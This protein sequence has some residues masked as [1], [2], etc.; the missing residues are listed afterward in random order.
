MLS[1]IFE[2]NWIKINDISDFNGDAYVALLE[3]WWLSWNDISIN[4]QSIVDSHNVID[5]P[6]FMQWRLITLWWWIIW[7]TE[8]NLISKINDINKSFSV[9]SYYK[10]RKDWYRDLVFYKNWATDNEKYFV[11]A[12]IKKLPRIDK[13]LHIHRKR[14][15][16]LELFCEESFIYSYL[17]KKQ[18]LDWSLNFSLPASL[19]WSLV[20]NRTDIVTNNWNCW[21][22][23]F[24]KITWAFRSIEIENI[25]NWQK[26]VMTWL[27]IVDWEYI[28]IDWKNWI[29]YKNWDK[30]IDLSEYMSLTSDWI[31]LDAWD[32][33][34]VFRWSEYVWNDNMPT[35]EITYRDTFNNIE[36]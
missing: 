4:T 22:T 31:F 17:E 8:E 20:K 24:I 18:L 2:Y 10:S 35:C 13:T 6:W 21:A 16:Y 29:V 19:P 1:T 28:E 7:K 34:V 5:Q 11:S 3:V 36:I 14:W 27:N 15:F 25:T 33:E 32:N 9:P 12:R 23:T 26:L 30:S